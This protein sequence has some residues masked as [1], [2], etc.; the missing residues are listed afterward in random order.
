MCHSATIIKY[1]ANH[2]QIKAY[3]IMLLQ[4]LQHNITDNT[5]YASMTA[6]IVQILCNQRKCNNSK[7]LEY[8]IMAGYYSIVMSYCHAITYA[9]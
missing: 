9:L 3:N 8:A 5:V 6:N 4:L 1:I 7:S 2:C